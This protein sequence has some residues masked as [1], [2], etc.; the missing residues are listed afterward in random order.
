[1]RNFLDHWVKKSHTYKEIVMRTVYQT[2]NLA[3]NDIKYKR[4]WYLSAIRGSNAKFSDFKSPVKNFVF[5]A[6]IF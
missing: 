6:S 3:K 2:E 4:W 1:M 5:L